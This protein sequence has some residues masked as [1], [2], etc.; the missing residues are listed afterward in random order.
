MKIKLTKTIKNGE[1]E[2][3]WTLE[4]KQWFPIS[5]SKIKLYLDLLD[6]NRDK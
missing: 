1:Q 4:L 3:S 2:I 5:I 6:K